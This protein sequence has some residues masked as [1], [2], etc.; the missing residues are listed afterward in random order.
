MKKIQGMIR[1]DLEAEQDLREATET[2][3]EAT[4]LFHSPCDSQAFRRW[5]EQTGFHLCEA[6]RRV[7]G[8]SLG[9]V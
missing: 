7:D 2:V 8:A 1:S 5:Q 4:C 3:G 6:P 9:L